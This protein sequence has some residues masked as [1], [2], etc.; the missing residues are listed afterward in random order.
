M[1]EKPD[2][3]EDRLVACLHQAYGMLVSQVDFLPLGADLN[4]AVYRVVADAGRAFFCKL[5]S[6]VFDETSAALPKYLRDQG[7]RPIIAPLA[8]QAGQ[9][10]TG[11]DAYTVI[12]YPYIEGRNGRE[13]A[14]SEQQWREFGTALKR[15]HTVAL[16]AGLQARI[17]QETY[18]PRWRNVVRAFL[19]R[20][21][22]ERF[23]DP[24]ARALTAYMR[25]KRKQIAD[26]VARAEQL[27]QVLIA[28]PRARVLCHSDVHGSNL[29]IGADGS[30]Y[31]VDWDDPI[32][33]P[34]ERDLMYVGGAQGFVGYT[35]QE[36]GTLFYRGYG[37]TLV[38][39]FEL[40]YYRYERIVED[41]AVYC[42]Q[43]LLSDEGGP[44]REQSLIYFKSNWDPD[45]TIE[46]AY[47]SDKTSMQ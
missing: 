19:E 33:A 25:D 11:L 43:L 26:L 18:S 38:D 8:T 27:A 20:I 6:G 45:G 40:A 41:I 14:L 39:P 17:R 34:K 30:L 21:D 28:Q 42:E 2:L 1:L 15:I 5:R 44:D 22:V 7:I 46:V 31:I 32:L 23:V 9:L 29:L 16:P 24:V 37:R 12:L 36:E 4:T 13:V 3:R 47:G 35:A 10:W